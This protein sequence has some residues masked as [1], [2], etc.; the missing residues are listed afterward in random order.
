MENAIAHTSIYFST[1]GCTHFFYTQEYIWCKRNT[2]NKICPWHT[3][4]IFNGTENVNENLQNVG[5]LHKSPDV[6]CI[7]LASSPVPN[8]P[9]L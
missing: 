7:V 8:P 4:T 9:T 1:N 3:H 2:C 6:G 5:N